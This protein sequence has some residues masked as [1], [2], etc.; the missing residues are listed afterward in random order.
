MQRRFVAVS[1][2]IVEE[3]ALIREG[4]R[5]LLERVRGVDV[6]GEAANGR[7]AITLI[8]KI[9]PD[10]AVLE[11]GLPLL[12]GIEV[13]RHLKKRS[14]RIRSIILSARSDE[15]H[16]VNALAAG[17]AGYVLKDAC[18]AEL[19][20]AIHSVYQGGC[21]LCPRISAHVISGL[22]DRRYNQKV[23]PRWELTVRQLEILQLVAEGHT[24]KEIAVLLHI[25]CKTVEAHRV[26]LMERTGTQD[27]AGLIRYAI[28]NGII[29]A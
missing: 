29:A 17:A 23:Q 22:Q 24:T 21:Y 1:V 3:Y 13:V 4:L 15:M 25:S 11:I 5:L 18:A 7:D 14:P 8:E 19:E 12:N 16:V 27:V 9:Q 6:V 26:R 10:I 20:F 2:I 28:R